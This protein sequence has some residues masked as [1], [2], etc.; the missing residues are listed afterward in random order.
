MLTRRG[1][2]ELE[3]ALA[4]S[5][6]STL[7]EELEWSTSSTAWRSS[8]LEELEGE[9]AT[10]GKTACEGVATLARH[11]VVRVVA[12]VETLSELCEGRP[13]NQNPTYGRIEEKSAYQDR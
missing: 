10:A 6:S 3:A 4:A 11:R 13:R 12:I 2:V 9:A 1:E 5:A 7:L 8:L